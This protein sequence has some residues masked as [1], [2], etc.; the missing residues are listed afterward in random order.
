MSWGAVAIA[1][2][3][4]IGG[5]M[6]AQQRAQAQTSANR[7]NIAMSAEELAQQERQFGQSV[8]IGEE[9]ARS[10][11]EFAGGQ[12]DPFSQTGR[13]AN[14]QQAALLGLGTP[15]E[16]AAAM[17]SFAESPGQRFMRERAEKS[18]LRN[19]AKI[20]GLGGG[21][22]RS[23]LVEQGVG[24]AAQDFGNQFARL[25][26]VAS[27]GLA[28]G[29]TLT[30]A[31]LGVSETALGLNKANQAAA[32]AKPATVAPVNRRDFRFD[33]EDPRFNAP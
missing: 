31:D 3:T 1:G 21:N 8:T 16:Q 7:A 17:E 28:A 2:A 6:S 19:E 9:R 26:T 29:Q 24:F 13:A 30:G 11:R 27:R 33:P 25:G 22:V 12:L 10:K 4:V 5:F 32:A 23:A 15:E 18:L 20:G 14:V